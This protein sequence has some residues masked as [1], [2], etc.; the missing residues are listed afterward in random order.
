LGTRRP[1]FGSKTRTTWNDAT[2]YY[3]NTGTAA[4]ATWLPLDLGYLTNITAGTGAA[5]KAVV[6]DGSGNVTLPGT[7]T[8]TGAITPTGG[9][10]AAWR[11]LGYAMRSDPH[12]RLSGDH[13]DQRHGINADHHFGL[14]L[15]D[16]HPVQH[17]DRGR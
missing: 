7:V 6:L 14:R 8:P 17:D 11:L 2:S 4:S 3:I 12:R 1:A 15:R 9:I 16:L 13:L 5:S 10:A